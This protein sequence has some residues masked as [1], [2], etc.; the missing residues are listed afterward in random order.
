[1]HDYGKPSTWTIDPETNRHRF[2][3]HDNVGA[4]LI[5]AD[6]KEL[7]F[8]KKQIEYISKMIKYHIYPSQLVSNEEI[9]DKAKLRF[10]NK[11]K[12]DVID[13]ILVAHADRN[14]A[15]GPDITKEMVENNRLK[16]DELLNGYFEE[17]SR[18]NL[19]L[20]LNGN[21]IM[22]ILNIPQSK[23]LGDIVKALKT[24]QIEKIVSTKE[25]AISFV[26]NMQ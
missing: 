14:S 13:V 24:A 19:P 20:L 15:L 17:R 4:E 7:K 12:D 6:L 16:L 8:S 23:Q 2:I 21:E 1:M 18:L 22:E 5:K 3:G 26:K 9:T 25:D 11:L 10:Y